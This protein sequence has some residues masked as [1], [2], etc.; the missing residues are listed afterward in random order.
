LPRDP[1]PCKWHRK[2][3]AGL[4]RLGR[5]SH[6]GA[7]GGASFAVFIPKTGSSVVSASANVWPIRKAWSNG[8]EATASAFDGSVPLASPS[9]LQDAANLVQLVVPNAAPVIAVP[10]R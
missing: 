3:S 10:W 1:K 5:P 6:F 9:A 4:P 7:P 2:P 8:S